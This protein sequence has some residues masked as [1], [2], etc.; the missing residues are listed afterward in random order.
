MTTATTSSIARGAIVLE[1]TYRAAPGRVFRAWED[2]EARAR[3]SKPWPEMDL[4][5]DSHDFRIGG[6][7]IYRC[8]L[9]GHFNWAAEV[10]YLD[11]VRDKR[12]IF[13]ERMAEEGKPQSTALITVEFFAKGKE[14]LQ[15]VTI[16]ILTL[17]GS[18][19]LEGYA[20]SWNPVLDNI[21]A[22][23]EQVA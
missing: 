19:M 23:V 8:G 7:D 22:E 10:H 4:V 9:D 15:I 6:T 1:R 18:G 5:Y 20:G 3:W 13:S 21:A 14:T 17:D 12:L 16:N 11:I 2:V